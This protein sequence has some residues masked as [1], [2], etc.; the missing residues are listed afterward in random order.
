LF[1]DV[2]VSQQR[3]CHAAGEGGGWRGRSAEAMGVAKEEES[4]KREDHTSTRV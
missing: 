4:E 3:Q 1:V 2:V